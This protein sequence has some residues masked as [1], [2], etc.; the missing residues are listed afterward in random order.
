MKLFLWALPFLFISGEVLAQNELKVEPENVG[1]STVFELAVSLDNTD[2]IAAIQFDL[3]YDVG[4]FNLLTNHSL[5]SRKEDHSITTNPLS[6]GVLRVV[7]FSMNNYVLKEDS[8]VLANLEFE[9]KTAPGD[10]TFVLSNVV[11]SS[12]SGTTIAATK[13][14]GQITVLGPKMRVINT[15]VDFGTVLLNSN[16]IRSLSIKNEGNEALV[17]SL[18]LIHISEPTRLV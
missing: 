14:D 3:T 1:Y 9:S 16:Q 17:I 4:T 15:Q 6:E 10:F 18:S 5:T 7:I 11:L 8:G 2:E 13:Q 12:P